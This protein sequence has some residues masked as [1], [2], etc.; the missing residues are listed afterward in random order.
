MI[1]WDIRFPDVSPKWISAAG[2][3]SAPWTGTAETL[4]AVSVRFEII[5]AITTPENSCG[6]RRMSQRCLAGGRNLLLKWPSQVTSRPLGESGCAACRAYGK[7]DPL[8]PSVM[9]N[10]AAF[11]GT[12]NLDAPPRAPLATPAPSRINGRRA[13]R[14]SDTTPSRRWCCALGI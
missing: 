11:I 4:S 8:L 7:P 5:S 14:R 2:F 9:T 13:G 12:S 10:G 6:S 1:R 3:E